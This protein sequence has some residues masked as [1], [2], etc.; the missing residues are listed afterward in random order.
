MTLCR[1]AGA[2]DE[3][4]VLHAQLTGAVVHLLHEQLRHPRHM[5]RQRHRRVVAGGYAHRLQQIVHRHLLTL[6]Q[7]HLTAT[8]PGGVST[9]R[10]HVVLRDA[11]AVDGLHGQQHRHD[12]GDAGGRQRVMLVLGVK[13][14]P[15]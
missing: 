7:K 12:L 11:A 9:D 4:G 15:C 14:L 8:H 2:V 6:R 13:D 10:H 3:V 5:L 1:Q